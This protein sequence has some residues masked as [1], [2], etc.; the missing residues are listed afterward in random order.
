MESN[1]IDKIE[2][3]SEINLEWFYHP[4]IIKEKHINLF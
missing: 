4:P 2:E 3:K 1:L